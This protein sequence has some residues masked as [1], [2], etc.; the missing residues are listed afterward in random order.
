ML[1][2]PKPWL[3]WLGALMF[4]NFAVPVYFFHTAEAKVTLI[5]GVLSM[6]LQ[7]VIFSKKGYVRLLGLGHLPWLPLGIW[8]FIRLQEWPL[9]NPIAIWIVLLI[10]L[11]FISLVIDGI[12]TV[13]YFRGEK[14]PT[15]VLP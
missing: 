14:K 11:N 1:L 13:R 2:L 10:S 7:M 4:V 6:I 9:S 3:L 12:Q 15:L 8:L 5:A